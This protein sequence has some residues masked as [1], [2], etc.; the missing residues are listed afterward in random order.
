[1]TPSPAPTP[2]P[3]ATE[4]ATLK[5]KFQNLEAVHNL[6]KGNGNKLSA[7]LIIH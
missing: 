6:V 2:S 7:Q 5:R 4:L 1:M 3:E